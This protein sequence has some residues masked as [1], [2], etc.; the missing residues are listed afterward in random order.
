MNY[1]RKLGFEETPD[2]DFL[3][4]LF[5][6]VLRVVN[7]VDDSMFDWKLLNN[8]KG[9]EAN[10]VRVLISLF[11]AISSD[12]LPPAQK[13][14]SN[15]LPQLAHHGGAQHRSRDNT[16]SPRQHR[17][18]AIPANAAGGPATP[19]GS[20]NP[21]Q[22]AALGRHASKQRKH[23]SAGLDRNATNSPSSGIRGNTADGRGDA[24]GS[25]AL[26]VGSARASRA[27]SPLQTQTQVGGGG[28]GNPILMPSPSPINGQPPQQQHPYAA[29]GAGMHTPAPYARAEYGGGGASPAVANGNGNGG[30][31]GGGLPGGSGMLAGS[32]QHGQSGQQRNSMMVNGN[33]GQPGIGSRGQIQQGL[34][35]ERSLP[36]PPRKVTLLDMLRC[37]CG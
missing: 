30:V 16:A 8:G 22:P 33:G 36:A 3:K 19:G 5:V 28:P 23:N 27:I 25:T 12:I 7:E 24:G 1:V 26:L 32:M 6:K 20:M 13:L 10:S 14:P 18:S 4:E 31:Y 35:E 2:Y 17:S 21:P 9:W 37:R 29:A 34:P 15:L 11:T